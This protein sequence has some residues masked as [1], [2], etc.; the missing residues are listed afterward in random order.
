MSVS[1]PNVDNISNIFKTIE[2]GLPAQKSGVGVDIDQFIGPELLDKSKGEYASISAGVDIEKQKPVIGAT[3]KKGQTEYGIAGSSSTDLGLGA[4][5]TSKDTSKYTSKDT[6]KK[7]TCCFAATFP[8]VRTWIVVSGSGG[9]A[10]SN[11]RAKHWGQAE[12]HK[13]HFRAAG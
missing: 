6:L 13:Q 4:Q 11:C 12:P 9:F 5:Y 1:F 8:G 2:K 10:K 3:V 7:T